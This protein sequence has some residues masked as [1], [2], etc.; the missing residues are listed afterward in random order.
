[1]FDV[2]RC[3]TTLCEMI[4]TLTGSP[5]EIVTRVADQPC[6]INA[7]AGQFEN[8]L[9]NMAVHARD[10]M[11]EGRLTITVRTVPDLPGPAQCP[12]RPPGYVAVSVA[13]TGVETPQAQLGSIFEPFFTTKDVG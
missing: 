12:E 13:D 4:R 3:V 7:N 10:A 8:A 9:I 2:R 1:M 5:I 11:G 6:F